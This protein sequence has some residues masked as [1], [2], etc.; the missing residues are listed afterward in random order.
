MSGFAITG[1]GMAVPDQVRSSV[2]LAE[3]FGV[4]EDWIVSRC[5]I[6]E[7]RIVGPGE[8]TASLAVLAGR[9]ALAKA[10]LTGADIAHLIVATATPEQP[11]PA[12]SA[13]VHHELGIEG[14]AH[15]VNAECSGFVYGLMTAAAWMALDPRPILVIGSDTH[16]LTVDPDDR[17]LSILVGDGAGAVVLTPSP[18]TWLQAWN[19]GADG[20]C[21]GSLKVP[22]GGSRM[23]TTKQTVR[24]GLHFARIKG[25]EIYLN[26]VR[27]S[28]RS[29]RATLASAKR[30]ADDVD[31]FVP[32]QANIRIIN[33]IMAHTGL[34]PERLVTNLE[35]Y[36]NTASGSVPIALTEALD[37]GRINDGDR[38]LLAGF[39]AGM[40]WGSMLLDWGGVTR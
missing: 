39:G 34:K 5:G 30:E 18:T 27:F 1:W 32:H 38:V 10:G 21:T 15:D 23:P 8:T 3:H 35:R 7:R 4:D 33:S 26:A 29:V 11:S 16:S 13:F 25:N 20:S 9:R 2:E 6:R 40:T 22:A 12:T 24:D 14:S 17:D 28:V 37:A 31:H 36:G 19:L